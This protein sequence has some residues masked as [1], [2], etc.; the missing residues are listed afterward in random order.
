MLFPWLLRHVWYQE[1]GRGP[2]KDSTLTAE[3]PAPQGKRLGPQ[4]RVCGWPGARGR[5]L[6][7]WPRWPLR[8]EAH[9]LSAELLT[10]L[11]ALLN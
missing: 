3:N 6:R 2:D 10:C 5:L 4:S 11:A 1:K 9:G 7:S 8:P